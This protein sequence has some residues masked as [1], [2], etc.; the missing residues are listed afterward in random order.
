MKTDLVFDP[1]L[2]VWLIALIILALILASGFGRWRGL[3]S[4]TFRSLAAL[5]LAGVLLNPQRLM[6]ERKALPDIALILTDHSE[7]MHIAGRDKMAAQV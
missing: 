1:L 5:F 6:E 2:P 4:F 7:S 3:K